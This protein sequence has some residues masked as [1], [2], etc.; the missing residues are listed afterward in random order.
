MEAKKLE[1]RREQMK[2]MDANERAAFEEKERQR[3]MNKKMK[4]MTVKM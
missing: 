2:N 4:K 1:K 3:K